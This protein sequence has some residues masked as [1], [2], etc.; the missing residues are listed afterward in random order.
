MF[1]EIAWVV[2]YHI[3][4]LGAEKESGADGWGWKMT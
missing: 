2:V 1:V 3:I 4:I